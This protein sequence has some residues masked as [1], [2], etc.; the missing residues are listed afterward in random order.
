MVIQFETQAKS[1]VEREIISSCA[2]GN[3][4]LSKHIYETYFNKVHE[5]EWCFG[6][7][8]YISRKK[9]CSEVSEWLQSI[10]VITNKEI[11]ANLFETH[12]EPKI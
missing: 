5:S 7:A 10:G 3:L 2:K 4:D 8:L 6:R 1:K 11:C 12:V 9:S